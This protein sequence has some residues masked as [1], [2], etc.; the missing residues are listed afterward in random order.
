MEQAQK[1][2]PV[3]SREKNRFIPVFL[4]IVCT[5]TVISLMYLKIDYTAILPYFRII[6]KN[7]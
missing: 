5:L 4:I 2:I 1:K 7:S 6:F 3:A